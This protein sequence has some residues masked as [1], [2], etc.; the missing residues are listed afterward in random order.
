ML[1]WFV[2]ACGIDPEPAPETIEPIVRQVALPSP[3]GPGTAR[4]VPDPIALT[5]EHAGVAKELDALT[6][7]R[8]STPGG[9]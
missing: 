5:G 2:L 9:R 1:F 6:R 4:Y 8:R 3:V 7:A